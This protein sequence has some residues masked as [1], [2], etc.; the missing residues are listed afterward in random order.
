MTTG[1]ADFLSLRK[2]QISSGNI[3]YSVTPDINTVQIEIFILHLYYIRKLV[4]NIQNTRRDK[5]SRMVVINGLAITAG[6]R[7]HF[8]AIKGKDAP[9]IFAI[10]MVINIDRDTISADFISTPSTP[11]TRPSN[12]S[13]LPKHTTARD[14]PKI[15]DTLNSFQ[16]TLKKSLKHIS[17][18]AIPLITVADA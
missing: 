2:I 11:N 14:N 13:N 9:T 12:K 6:S 10:I 4:A 16:I 1:L 18:T 3:T 15:I 5:I 7:W 17:L 8:L